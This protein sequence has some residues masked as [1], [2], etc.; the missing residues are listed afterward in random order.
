LI[1]KRNIL[2]VNCNIQAQFC[3]LIGVDNAYSREWKPAEL[4]LNY[5][6]NSSVEHKISPVGSL[7]C[8]V[9]VFNI[10]D[11]KVK[12]FLSPSSCVSWSQW[13]VPCTNISLSWD[14]QSIK[15]ALQRCVGVKVNG[16]W[17]KKT[18][19]WTKMFSVPGILRLS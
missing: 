7:S 16:R 12:M 9:H 19:I 5:F 4:K 18:K 1:K 10:R 13:D 11:T 17:D 2:V 8:I 15:I 3:C 6:S 14:F